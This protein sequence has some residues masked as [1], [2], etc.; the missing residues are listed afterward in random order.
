MAESRLAES[1]LISDAHRTG[2]REGPAWAVFQGAGAILLASLLAGCA[3]APRVHQP[4]QAAPA[5]QLFRTVDGKV[6][7]TEEARAAYLHRHN[8]L[9][10]DLIAL[11]L[12][13]QQILSGSL[14]A[15][16]EARRRIRADRFAD[17]SRSAEQ[18]LAQAERAERRAE[19]A[20]RRARTEA[21]ET[22]AERD[23]LRAQR[24]RQRAERDA[25]RVARRAADTA[26]HA[27][28]GPFD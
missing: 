8:A 27:Q 7:A 3:G 9:E 28:L 20:L 19:R 24:D 25:R 18:R 15:Q 1:R 22:A 23:L 5:P 4:L 26:R 16:Q 12:K 2:E 14:S 21:Q 11:E 13:R 10:R 6:F 17:R